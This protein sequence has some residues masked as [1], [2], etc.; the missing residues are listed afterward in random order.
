MMQRRHGG[1]RIRMDEPPPDIQ[2]HLA[3]MADDIDDQMEGGPSS[4]VGT[5]MTRLR[6][7]GGVPLKAPIID[8]DDDD[9]FFGGG[10]VV[11]IQPLPKKIKQKR[12]PRAPKQPRPPK[13]PKEPRVRREHEEKEQ[14]T[15]RE[16][17][18]TTD[19][20]SLFYI[21][22]HSKSSIS[23]IVDD[24]IDNYKADRDSA[25]IVLMQ[26]FINASGCKGK[27]TPEM[28]TSLE[29]TA[30]IRKMTEEFDEESG[31]YP[32]IM[33]GQQWKKFKTNFCD[34]VQNLVRQC[35]FLIDWLIGFTS[36]CI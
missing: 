26:F 30:I 34:F 28:Q 15:D 9:I 23:S 16:R 14:T 18:I 11:P 19:E 5:R 22:R 32:L 29:H 17:E 13:L 20:N 3:E 25:L 1:K 36:T 12:E 33:P 27:I 7:R 4:G 35:N 21:I 2:E 31:E 8:D 24:W 10:A 6:A